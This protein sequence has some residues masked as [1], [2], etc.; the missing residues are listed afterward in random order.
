MRKNHQQSLVRDIVSGQRFNRPMGGYAGVVN[1]GQNDTW[2][3]S[4]LAMSNLYAFGKLA[5]A[6]TSDPTEM[7]QEWTRLVSR[8]SFFRFLYMLPRLIY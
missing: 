8:R 5:W 7:L 6:P 3:G 2:L 4:H 1:V